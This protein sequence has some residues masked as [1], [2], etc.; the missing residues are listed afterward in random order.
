MNE[1]RFDAGLISRAVR[2]RLVVFDFDGVFTDNTV[3]VSEDGRES[4]RCFRGDGLGLRK[5]ELLGI[6]TLILSTEVNPVV[7]VRAQ[8]LRIPCIHGVENKL[9]RLS[10]EITHRQLTFEQVAYVGNDI[11]DSTCL[12]RV[13]LPIVVADAHPDVIPL[14]YY[15]TRRL[16]GR[17]AVREVC[18][19]LSQIIN[20][21]PI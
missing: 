21:R 3:L 20:E 6:E 16:G 2:L 14:A 8:K 11:N 13:G 17:G 10:S 1:C 4:V 15:Q 5:L 18:D 12:E 7:A 19:V 9:E